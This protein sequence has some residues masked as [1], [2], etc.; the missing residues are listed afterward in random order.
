MQLHQV[1][2]KYWSDLV[3]LHEELM[4]L[5]A[6]LNPGERGTAPAKSKHARLKIFLEHV[7]KAMKAL[8]V[9][10]EKSELLEEKAVDHLEEHI[11]SVL[12]PIK[13]RLESLRDA[14]AV[15][16]LSLANIGGDMADLGGDKLKDEG[17][18]LLGEGR[19]SPDSV[20]SLYKM[21]DGFGDADLTTSSEAIG[22]SLDDMTPDT[23]LSAGLPLCE[24]LED[25]DDKSHERPPPDAPSAKR[26]RVGNGADEEPVVIKCA[27]QPSA[28]ADSMGKDSKAKEE[29]KNVPFNLLPREVKYQCA[30][31]N[32]PYS[33]TFNYNPWWALRLEECPHCNK[34]QVPR[35]DISHPTNQIDYHPALS[36]VAEAMSLSQAN[37]GKDNEINTDTESDL[38][39]E[40]SLSPDKS[41]K[42]LILICHARTCPGKHRSK[43]HA[44]VCKSIKYL[45]L[46]IRDCSGRL[47]DGQ[48]CPFEW[49]RPCK[50]LLSHLVKCFEPNTCAICNPFNLPRS[51]EQL[52]T[53]NRLREQVTAS[54]AS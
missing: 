18:D 11:T 51:M 8:Q 4:H 36:A 10:P 40:F 6:Q 17:T 37:D 46:H 52:M 20:D 3:G 23:D 24:V 43:R 22:Y 31:C 49:C 38:N 19:D 12:L 47:P 14:M 5:T 44:E 25:L 30:E 35:L 29:S 28:A 50:K 21:E 54:T 27:E 16:T 53:L 13:I 42:L 7:R 34:R 39:D 9:I 41:S 33:V 15:E 32:E 2:S 48:S 45:M 1:R 26:Q